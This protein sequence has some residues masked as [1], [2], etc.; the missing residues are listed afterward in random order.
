MQTLLGGPRSALNAADVAESLT[1]ARGATV[2]HGVDVLDRNGVVTSDVL[3]MVG[4][5]VAWQWRAPELGGQSGQSLAAVRRQA[6]L[7]VV[8]AVPDLAMVRLRLWTQWRLRNGLWARW[9]LGVFGVTDPGAVTD[10]GMVVRRS[11]TLADKTQEWASVPLVQPLVVPAGTVAVPWV[12]QRLRDVF[13][14]VRFALASSDAALGQDRVFE[15]GTS[16]LEVMSRVLE[17]VGMDQLIADEDGTP[18]AQPLAVLAGQGPFAAYGPGAAKIVPAGDVQ[19]LLP[20]LPNVVVFSARQGPSLGNVEGNGL[21]TRT[22]V[23]TGPSSV[24]ARGGRQV[25]HRVEVEV[26]DQAALDAYADAQ[27]GRFFA[28]GGLTFSGSVAL[29]PQFSDRD[30]ISLRLPRIGVSG[31][32]VVTSWTYPLGPVTSAQEVLMPITAERR[33]SA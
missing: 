4:G 17:A 13:G 30:V 19:A 22:N 14:E 11:L 10:D 29:N 7:E 6:S 21:A 20:S 24:T 12:T 16:E 2:R 23:S 15:A 33:V 27:A 9:H 26:D 25:V 5:R 3:R 31:E 32:W 18:S 1:L 8:G 28:G